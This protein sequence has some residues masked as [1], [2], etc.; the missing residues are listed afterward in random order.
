MPSSVRS[1]LAWS[2]RESLVVAGIFAAWALAFLAL[3]VV[4]G[5]VLLLFR[6]VLPPHLIGELLSDIV[7]G[8]QSLLVPVVTQGAMATVA[9]YVLARAGVVIVDHYRGDDVMA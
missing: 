8:G 7:H 4:L 9:L 6:V 1:R 3:R 2:V 5:V